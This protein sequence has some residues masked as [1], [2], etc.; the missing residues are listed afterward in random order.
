M[1]PEAGNSAHIRNLINHQVKP[2]INWNNR[3]NQIESIQRASIQSSDWLND[4]QPKESIELWIRRIAT[5]IWGG[6]VRPMSGHVTPNPLDE[7]WWHAINHSR[8]KLAEL[9]HTHTHTH[10][11]ASASANRK[12][13]V[14]KSAAMGAS[15]HAT[16][17]TA[18]QI[19]PSLPPPRKP[20]HHQIL[21]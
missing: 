14:E 5:L 13:G 3:R 4:P 8:I 2:A 7:S 15:Y 18:N 21:F 16:A 20:N 17:D 19:H 12:S 10:A 11:R 1:K 9:T 6:K